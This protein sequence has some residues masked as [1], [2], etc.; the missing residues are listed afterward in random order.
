VLEE[1]RFLIAQSPEKFRAALRINSIESRG[2]FYAK[3]RDPAFRPTLVG[4]DS[5]GKVQKRIK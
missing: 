4:R 3:A 5:R 2:N 1:C